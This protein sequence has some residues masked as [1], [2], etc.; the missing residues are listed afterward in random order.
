IGWWLATTSGCQQQPTEVGDAATEQQIADEISAAEILDRLRR[1]YATTNHYSDRATLELSYRLQGR[2]MDE[3][4]Q[5]SVQFGRNR[6]LRVDLY[7]ARIRADQQQLGCFVYDF[8][9]ANLDNQWQVHP[10]QGSYPLE[11]LFQDGIC[12]HYISGHAEL[13]VNAAR[14]ECDDAF[15]P[16]TVGLLTGQGMPQWFEQGIAESVAE[17]M[18]EGRKS[19]RLTVVHDKLAYHLLIDPDAYLLQSI[20]YPAELLDARLQQNPEVQGLSLTARFAGATFDEFQDVSGFTVDV[21]HDARIVSHFVAVPQPFPSSEVG[22]SIADLQLRDTATELV[23][24]DDWSGKVTLLFWTNHAFLTPEL[25]ATIETVADRLRGREYNIMRVES[26]EGELP[27]NPQTIERLTGIAQTTSAVVVADFGFAGG[28]LAGLESWPTLAIIDRDGAL[29]YVKNMLDDPLSPEEIAAVMLRVRSG[30][31]VADEMRSDYE[32][33]LDLYQELLVEALINGPITGDDGLLVATAAPTRFDI[34]PLWQNDS[35]QQPGNILASSERVIVLDGWRTLA[36]L[37]DNGRVLQQQ[38]LE[39]DKQESANI[40][41]RGQMQPERILVFSLM[42]RAVRVLNDSLDIVCN[43][44]AG[45]SKQRIRDAH[46]FDV[47]ADGQDE[48][49]V[50]FTGERGTEVHELD[51]TNE[52]RTLTPQSLRSFAIFRATSGK[53]SLLLADTAGNLEAWE[54]G[55]PEKVTIETDL[56]AATHISVQV[57]AR[58]EMTICVIGTDRQGQWTAVGLDHQLQQK[59]SVPVG[60]Q[61]FD[62]Q[63][64][65]IAFA[66]RAGTR[67]GFWAIAGADGS[68]RLISDD[69]RLVDTWAT[70][71]Q[72]RGIA[73]VAEDHHYLVILSTDEQVQAWSLSDDSATIMSTSSGSR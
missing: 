18:V 59:W 53:Q 67:A 63:I 44:N 56:L 36:S 8:G 27:G 34:K 50:S 2:Y 61:R 55:A 72:L 14:T 47:D 21:P 60:S 22:N 58:G 31:K 10:C 3:P 32:S 38:V 4:H 20:S 65:S 11:K 69:G 7:E 52:S 24:Q 51:A 29:Q 45:L 19:L 28:R 39:L 70:G 62:T 66:H 64:E 23:N 9:S 68:I 12:R 35:L 1:A 26:I 5:W 49:I 57:D 54:N 33:L 30:E 40:I 16:I 15:F 13:P 25:A 42:G 73:L 48:L 41:R 43:V 46:L 17:E 37:G 71:A 6:G